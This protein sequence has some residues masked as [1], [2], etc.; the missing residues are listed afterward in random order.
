MVLSSPPSGNSPGTPDSTLRIERRTVPDVA[1]PEDLPPVLRRVYAARGIAG[2]EDLDLGLSRLPDFG[3]FADIGAAA[4][5][6]GDALRRDQRILVVG[7]FDADGATATALAVAGLRALGAAKVDCL[8]PDRA[9]HGYGLSPAI[10]EVARPLRPDLILTVDNGIASVEGVAAARALGCRVVI[11]DHHLPPPRLPAAD[12]I[13]NPNREDCGFPDKSL[14]GVGVMFYV[15]SALRDRLRGEGWFGERRAPALADYLD[16][17]ALGTVAD[18]VPLG[19]TNRVLVAQGLRRIRAGR[20][21]PGVYALADA[22]GRDPARLVAADIGFGLAPRL[23]AAGRLENMALGIECLLAEGPAPARRAASQLEALNSERRQRQEA[24]QATAFA[25]VDRLELDAEGLPAGLCLHDADWHEGIIGLVAGRVKERY[26]RPAVAFAEAGEGGLKG[27]A[28]S[29]PGVHIRD[30]LESLANRHPGLI[31]RFGGHAMAA[32]LTLAGERLPA[33]RQAFAEEIERRVTPEML[34]D[35]VLT[36]GE[37]SAAEFN[38]ETALALQD[39]GPWGAGF[40]EP[41]FDG[42]FDVLDQRVVGGRHLKMRLRAAG[43]PVLDAIAFNHDRP[44]APRVTAVYRLDINR[45]RGVDTLQLVV[46][47]LA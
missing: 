42:E 30:A 41:V 28:R 5:C 24:M 29:I 18:V 9:R 43:G 19:Y 11:T 20:A 7:D 39:G 38:L 17:V 13:V 3:R 6:L 31:E 44:V 8:V 40:P 46:E 2:P 23:N 16:L 37:L 33:F 21:R 34:A 36:D 35:V 4:A 14:A 12:A 27:S 32:G 47:R 25:V 22:A 26:R 45:Y 1:L 15:L 10:V